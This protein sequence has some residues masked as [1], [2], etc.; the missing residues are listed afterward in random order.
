MIKKSKAFYNTSRYAHIH[1]CLD[2]FIQYTSI[3]NVD[4]IFCITCAINSYTIQRAMQTRKNI[5]HYQDLC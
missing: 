1:T 4:C 5:I 2:T 3:V